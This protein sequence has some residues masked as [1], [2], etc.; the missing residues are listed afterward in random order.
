MWRPI[1]SIFIA[2]IRQCSH[3]LHLHPRSLLEVF[4]IKSSKVVY[5]MVHT[6]WISGHTIV[7]SILGAS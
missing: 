1:R 7:I 5:H 6:E 2:I 3:D 4:N